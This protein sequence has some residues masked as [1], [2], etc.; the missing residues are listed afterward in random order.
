MAI[1][2]NTYS[3]THHHHPIERAIYFKP[4]RKKVQYINDGLCETES[5][6][7]KKEEKR[8]EIRKCK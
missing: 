5:D 4:I 3:L 8:F 2:Y 6:C 1:T 7:S